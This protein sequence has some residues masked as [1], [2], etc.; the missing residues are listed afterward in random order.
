MAL[1]NAFASGMARYRA[2][3]FP[4]D[5]Q[6]ARARAHSAQLFLNAPWRAIPHKT[7]LDFHG[8]GFGA[9]LVDLRATCIAALLNTTPS[10]V[11][12]SM[13][14][15]RFTTTPSTAMTSRLRPSQAVSSR[16]LGIATWVTYGSSVPATCSTPAS[17]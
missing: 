17:F 9:S 7:L 2:A 8:L 1:H 14:T 5:A 6:L 13:P 4:P 11:P 15:A 3:F 16:D 10:Q 12:Q